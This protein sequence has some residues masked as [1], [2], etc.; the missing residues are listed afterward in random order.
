MGERAVVTGG[1]DD[2]GP[3]EDPQLAEV[4][5]AERSQGLWGMAGADLAGIFASGHSA[6]IVD[7]VL[8]RPLSPP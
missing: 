4:S 2:L 1:I 5:V 3:A 8:D 7:P 6:N